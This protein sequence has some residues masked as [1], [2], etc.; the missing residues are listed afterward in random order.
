MAQ[1]ARDIHESID[2]TRGELATTLDAL[3]GK[4]DALVAKTHVFQGRVHAA[5]S[6]VVAAAKHWLPYVIVAFIV[7]LL[8]GRRTGRRSA[9]RGIANLTQPSDSPLT[10]AWDAAAVPL[11]PDS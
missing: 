4:K 10:I 11:A 7:G 2:R 9:A 5:V 8:V 1:D 6:F 3:V